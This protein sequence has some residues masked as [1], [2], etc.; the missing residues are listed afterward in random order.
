MAQIAEMTQKD[1]SCNV[2]EI[3]MTY[4]THL[5]QVTGTSV[6]HGFNIETM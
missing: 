3:K 1:G 6:L 4:V 2:E 5:V